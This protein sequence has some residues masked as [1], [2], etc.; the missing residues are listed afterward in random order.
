MDLLFEAVNL[1]MMPWWL[2]WIWA[3][4]SEISARIASKP[5]PVM[6]PVL[7]YLIL[8]GPL[9][10]QLLPELAHPKL[11]PITEFLSEPMGAFAGWLHFLVMDFL[12]GAWVV[13]R[14]QN[15]GEKANPWTIRF[16]L[17]ATLMFGPIGAFLSFVL[18]PVPAHGTEKN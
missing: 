10:P 3:P 6:I 1:W 17:I 4:K 9:L 7:V 8:V 14:S 11:G 16:V 15:L 18:L 13:F 2:I 5:W 12:V